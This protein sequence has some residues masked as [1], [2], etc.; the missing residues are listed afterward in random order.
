[1]SIMNNLT[2]IKIYS[3]LRIITGTLLA[4]CLILLTA[5]IVSAEPPQTLN[6]SGKASFYSG[7]EYSEIRL[8]TTSADPEWL[9]E[10]ELQ[11]AA[12]SYNPNLSRTYKITGSF[13]L[14][15]SGE[16]L[17]SGNANGWWNSSGP[18]EIKL[19]G[20]DSSTSLDMF[21]VI[22]NSGNVTAE[23]RGVWPDYPAESEN[24]ISGVLYL[25]SK[26]S[27]ML[28][29]L[30][31]FVNLFFILLSTNKHLSRYSKG[32]YDNSLHMMTGLLCIFTAI[33][34]IAALISVFANGVDIISGINASNLPLISAGAIG[35]LLLLLIPPA[36][37]LFQ[38]NVNS[39]TSTLYF[40]AFIIILTHAFFTGS[41]SGTTWV[42]IIYAI[43]ASLIL[44]LASFNLLL[45]L[46]NHIISI[47][48]HR[49]ISLK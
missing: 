25:I 29:Y 20:A 41:D 15:V 45:I 4:F 21:F 26:T 32:W 9:L 7:S 36:K 18:G 31:I 44:I 6:M 16:P 1:M 17:I 12:F 30:L 19:S 22:S 14:G 8:K 35:F 13:V 37:I 47:I 3:I 38:K 11:P 10:I 5:G 2:G 40:I 33:L 39:L 43:T 46:K 49:Y 42:R 48:R 27:G 24:T 34:H 28:T 23:V